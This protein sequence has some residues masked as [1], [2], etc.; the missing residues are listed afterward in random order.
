[1]RHAT[2]IV[3]STFG[4]LVG[5]AGLEHGAG[6]ILQ[7]HIVAYLSARWLGTATVRPVRC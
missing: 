1:M 2:A 3:V 5:L 4:V 6:E 7:G